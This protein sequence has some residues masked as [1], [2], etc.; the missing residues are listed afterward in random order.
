MSQKNYSGSLALTKLIHV[1]M[2]VKGKSGKMVKGI[3]IPVE[4]NYLVE[5]KE[6]ALYMPIRAIVKD[7]QDDRGQNGFISQSVD[8]KV[9]KEA[10][11]AQKETFKK[12]PILGNLKDFSEGGNDNAGQ[13]SDQIFTPQSDDLPF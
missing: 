8:T 12:M 9:Y 4:E 7:T 1:R 11:D 2:E 3:F 6:N 10:T 5:G 13:K